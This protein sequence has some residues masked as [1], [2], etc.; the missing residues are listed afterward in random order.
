MPKSEEVMGK[1]ATLLTLA[2]LLQ[3]IN[4]EFI[5]PSSEA[6]PFCVAITAEE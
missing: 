1:R 5:S 3:V 6:P 4:I 2:A